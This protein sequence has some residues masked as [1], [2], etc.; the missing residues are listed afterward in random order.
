[1]LATCGKVLGA[2]VTVGILGDAVMPEPFGAVIQFGAMG[3][4]GYMVVSNERDRRRLLETLTKQDV[5]HAEQ[6]RV[7]QEKLERLHDE[8]IDVIRKCKRE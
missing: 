6:T 2:L 8:T 5:A 1:M 7:A 4:C 3:L